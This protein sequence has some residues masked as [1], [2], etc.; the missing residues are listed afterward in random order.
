VEIKE[1]THVQKKKYKNKAT[2]NPDEL[3][4]EI[5]MQM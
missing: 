2:K 1:E 3:D 5:P 4:K